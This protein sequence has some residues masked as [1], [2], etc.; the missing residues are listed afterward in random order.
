[1]YKILKYRRVK[2]LNTN[3][4]IGKKKLLFFTNSLV[5][6]FRGFW[7]WVTISSNILEERDERPTRPARHAARVQVGRRHEVSHLAH[8]CYVHVQP[9]AAN[10]VL[11]RQNS[12]SHLVTSNI[13]LSDRSNILNCSTVKNF[14][15]LFGNDT[16]S[17]NC[18]RK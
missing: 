8:A 6:M 4:I 3:M 18:P 5:L 1:M 15:L 11:K 9:V 13:F 2:S 17:L 16:F 14:Y 12:A 10:E 7:F